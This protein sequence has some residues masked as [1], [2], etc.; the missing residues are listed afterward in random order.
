MAPE[1]AKGGTAAKISTPGAITSGFKI[2]GFTGSGPR[3]KYVATNGVGAG[4]TIVPRGAAIE[5]PGRELHNLNIGPVASYELAL[6][7]SKCFFFFFFF[8]SF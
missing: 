8:I 4:A 3:E 1:T 6:T 2:E 5:A 7:N